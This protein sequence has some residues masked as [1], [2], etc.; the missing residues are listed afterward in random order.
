MFPGYLFVE[1]FSLDLQVRLDVLKTSGVV[2]IL[3]NPSGS[4]PVPIPNEKIESIKRIVDSKVEIRHFQYPK[5][6]EPARIIDGPFKG[7]E[8]L[9][10]SAD[11]KKDL[12]VISLELLQRSIAI[13]IEGFQIEKI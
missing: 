7:I 11:L 1:L 8:G 9:V 3:G 12:F 10:L 13:K 2:K 6:G 4:E 5:V